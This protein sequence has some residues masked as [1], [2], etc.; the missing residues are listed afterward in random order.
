MSMTSTN[1]RD[2]ERASE[3]PTH[4][5]LAEAQDYL[6]AATVAC[7]VA[8]R[9]RRNRFVASDA[10]ASAERDVWQALVLDAV[11][12]AALAGVRTVTARREAVVAAIAKAAE[13]SVGDV[14]DVV[15]DWAPVETLISAAAKAYVSG[16]TDPDRFWAR[17][18]AAAHAAWLAIG[19]EPRKPQYYNAYNSAVFDLASVVRHGETDPSACLVALASAATH[20]ARAGRSRGV[21]RA[22]ATLEEIE[23]LR[24]KE[25]QS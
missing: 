25:P 13:T 23:E 15:D 22:L 11:A 18:T 21:L 4:R 24:I 10:L 19:P 2:V 3:R 14:V 5:T 20:L 12:D 1:Q 7:R 8:A 17:L 6:A 9:H 16:H